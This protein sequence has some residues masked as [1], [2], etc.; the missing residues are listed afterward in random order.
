MLQHEAAGSWSASAIC[1]L[2]QSASSGLG[3]S[4]IRYITVGRPGAVPHVDVP[5]KI[6]WLKDLIQLRA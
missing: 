4:W 6:S 5:G 2:G 1:E 3:L